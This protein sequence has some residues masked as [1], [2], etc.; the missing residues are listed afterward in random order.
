MSGIHETRESV[1][2]VGW[3]W[4]ALPKLIVIRQLPLLKNGF[5]DEHM[6]G[7]GPTLRADIGN[8][9]GLGGD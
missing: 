1:Q 9:D 5:V 7:R 2:R 6:F 8:E 4:I 3:S